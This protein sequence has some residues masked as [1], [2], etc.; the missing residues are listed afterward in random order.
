LEL[1][2]FLDTGL[3][4][5]TLINFFSAKTNLFIILICA[6][7]LVLSTSRFFRAASLV[8]V[9]FEESSQQIFSLRFHSNP[10]GASSERQAAIERSPRRMAC[11][12]VHE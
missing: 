1:K 5:A 4:F 3:I 10:A 11:S 6:T 9:G 2:Y 7:F 12:L 8:L